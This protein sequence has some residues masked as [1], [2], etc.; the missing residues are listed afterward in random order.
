MERWS[1]KT[2]LA[3]HEVVHGVAAPR[4][5]GDRFPHM[6]K[7]SPTMLRVLAAS[8]CGKGVHGVGLYTLG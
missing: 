3:A 4:D 2:T 5:G 7:F 8:S 6:V 1:E